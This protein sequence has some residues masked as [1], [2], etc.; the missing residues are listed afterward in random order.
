MEIATFGFDPGL[1]HGAIVHAT[2]DLSPKRHV[3]LEAE[4]VYQW[5]EKDEVSL[6][7]KSPLLQIAVFVQSGLIPQFTKPAMNC[8]IEFSPSSVYWTRQRG[9]VVSLA[10]MLGFLMHG[11]LAA[12]LPTT[13]IT[14]DQL[15]KAFSI[16]PREG[17]AYM[18]RRIELIECP[19]LR[20][21]KEFN[22][23]EQTD[24]IFDAFLLAYLTAHL[25]TRKSS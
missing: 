5:T 4:V 10:F 21:P 8:G 7:S 24:D 19:V 18:E 17:K 11:L 20:L 6:A 12:G 3:C 25:L 2:F 13:F 14:V 23:H 15:K 16:S 1:R 22:P 9:Q